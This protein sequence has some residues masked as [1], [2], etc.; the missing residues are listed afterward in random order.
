[1]VAVSM[2]VAAE[3]MLFMR[4]AAG[5]KKIV[6]IM[7]IAKIEDVYLSTLATTSL[8]TFMYVWY[9]VSTIPSS[10]MQKIKPW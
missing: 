4:V 6:T 5:Q 8:L 3:T 2:F 1:M 7:M 9:V 10:F